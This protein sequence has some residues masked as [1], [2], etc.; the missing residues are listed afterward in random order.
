MP[1]V[2][3]RHIRLAYTGLKELTKAKEAYQ[4]ACVLDPSN[5]SYQT[6]LRIAEQKLQETSLN[7]DG[8]NPGPG[9]DLGSLGPSLGGLDLSSLMSNPALMNMASSMLQNPNM[10]QMMQSMMGQ[11]MQG[12]PDE[13]GTEG[14]AAMGNLLQIY[15]N[16][17]PPQIGLLHQSQCD[18][19]WATH[20]LEG[21]L[22]TVKKLP[23]STAIR[24]RA[25]RFICG[26][27]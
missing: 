3:T 23:T 16:P 26:H 19:M 18:R 2:W 22:R 17:L 4:K 12:N 27:P 11:A 6:N 21:T 8:A 25:S 20:H 5:E 13:G 24:T 7:A 14:P 9:I 15:T 10:Q 1:Y